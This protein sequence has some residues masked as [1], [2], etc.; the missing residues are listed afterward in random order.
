MAALYQIIPLEANLRSAPK[1]DPRNI[2]AQLK[3]GQQV[4][5]LPAL[6]AQPTAWRRVQ[7]DVQGT[8]V[9]GYVKA[10]LLQKTTAVIVPPPPAV[11]PTLPEAHLPTKQP[12][13]ISNPDLRAYSLNDPQQPR[14][15]GTASAA[16]VQ[17]LGAIL[18]YL[19]VEAAARY[20][21][22]PSA[23]FCN[24]YAH[25]YC[26]LAGV[27][28]PRVWWR[29]KALAQLVQG[30]KPAV[31]YGVTVE[32]YNVTALFNWLEEFGPDFG[33]RRT[34]S[35][36]D[37]QQAANLGQVAIIAAQRT[38]LNAPG[39]I[40]AIVPE[41]AQH[42]ATRK[43]AVVT[44]PLQSQAGATNFRYGGRTWWS[45]TQFR[46]FGFWIHA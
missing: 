9:E 26:H 23:T 7:A 1:L 27:Y 45:G 40:V 29:A 34:V 3:Q 36:A 14:R 19:R 12:V 37:L 35:V 11:L 39:H 4:Q 30:H 21:R 20:K 28:L 6:P 17:E 8:A 46:R 2:L 32:E 44:V 5:E 42:K 31:T 41:T 18:D 24:I 25:D 43:G 10:S 33:W 15:T 13:R 22:T 16:R 38:N